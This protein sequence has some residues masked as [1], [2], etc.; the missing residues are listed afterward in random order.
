MKNSLRAVRGT[1]DL[2]GDDMR[3]HRHIADTAHDICALYGF[4]E[5]SAPIFE[6]T[7]VFHRTL[8]ESSD[9]ISKETYTFEDRGGESITLRPELTA[10]IMRAF[11][12]G[13]HTQNL[14]FKAFYAGPAFR[15]ERPQ[16][17][18]QRQFHQVGVELIGADSPSDDIQV[19]ACAKQFLDSLGLG[20]GGC[21]TL[22]L[23][24]LG[25]SESRAA[26][27][28]A[29]VEYLTS[30]K[31]K[32]SDE[33]QVRLEQNPLRVLD[34]KQAEDK[35]I[36]ANAPR[37]E[38][39]FTSAARDWF[40]S[41]TKGLDALGIEYK[42]NSHLVRGLDYY[43]H[44]VFEFTSNALG[45]QNTVLAGGRYDGLSEMMGGP[46]VTGI[47]WAAGI[48]RLSLTLQEVVK[49]G[50][51]DILADKPRPIAV[52]PFD[53]SAANHAISLLQNLRMHGIY[54]ELLEK[55]NMGKRFKKADKMNAS[56]ALVLGE[57]EVSGG[58]VTV[59][60]LSDGS[61]AQVARDDII[62]WLSDS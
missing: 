27:R 38:E 58:F 24:S 9:V 20:A 42:L 52:L 43:N 28:E 12:S 37:L 11:I 18:R 51:E 50:G 62:G 45:A 39:Y 23:N 3:Y 36:V 13:G 6:F 60:N 49:S 21:V 44:T 48:E 19:I 15:Y 61:Q 41:V 5:M 2:I 26:Y 53:A 32:L 22:E 34:S 14:P 1:H 29:L 31:A 25:D 57:D 56:H 17:G 4:N 10:G 35:E 59:K 54:S 16:K 8:G 55:G 46:A 33:S 30:H 40:A 7:E 47:G